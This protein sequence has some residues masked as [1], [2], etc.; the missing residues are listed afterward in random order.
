MELVQEYLNLKSFIKNKK[1][2]G[3]I[4]EYLLKNNY[5]IDE[6]KKIGFQADRNLL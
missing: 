4:Y 3:V 2:K 6:G 5:P 1:Y